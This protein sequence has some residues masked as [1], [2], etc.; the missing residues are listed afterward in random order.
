MLKE[1]TTMNPHDRTDPPES[2]ITD[3]QRLEYV[4]NNKK[5]DI[6]TNMRDSVYVDDVFDLMFQHKYGELSQL[7]LSE[8]LDKIVDV[9][10]GSVS[11]DVTDAEIKQ[12]IA[13][14]YE[15]EY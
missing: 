4:I 11:D 2:D 8:E 6:I 5:D 3:E 10:T 15:E 1:I 9:A 14:D 12:A 7:K 13:D